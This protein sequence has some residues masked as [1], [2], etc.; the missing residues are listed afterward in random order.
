MITPK[1]FIY[2]APLPED[3]VLGG[4]S[5][6]NYEVLQEDGNWYDFLPNTETQIRKID[7]YNCTSEGSLNA[8]EALMKR[9]F[10][11]EWDFSQRAT[12]IAAGTRPPG[13]TPNK[14]IE[15]IRKEPCMIPETML[16]FTDQIE[17]VEQYYSPDPLNSDHRYIGKKFLDTYEIGHEWVDPTR[18]NLKE[19]L[20][21]SPVGISVDAWNEDAKGMYYS[22]KQDNHWTV[23]YGIREDGSY[24]IFDSYAPFLKVL[25]PDFKFM[26]AKRYSIKKKEPK[27]CFLCKWFPD[28][29][30]E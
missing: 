5:K 21:Y 13:N 30:S 26:Q 27:R 2:E 19:A 22:A 9:K 16:P 25:R 23:L 10:G 29:C 17:T 18:I 28:L 11:G 7:S 6:L 8:L 3:Y 20:K 1:G 14:V 15:T 24:L 12:G 4:F